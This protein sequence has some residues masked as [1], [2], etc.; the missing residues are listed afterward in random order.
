MWV[1]PEI[2]ALAQALR[3][4]SIAFRKGFPQSNTEFSTIYFD[5][6]ITESINLS[7]LNDAISKKV[8]YHF[9]KQVTNTKS[10]IQ[11]QNSALKPENVSRGRNIWIIYNLLSNIPTLDHWSILR[12]YRV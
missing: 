2:T 8:V 11:K 9:D 12:P 6:L 4:L 3:H 10:T 5:I 1:S 7:L